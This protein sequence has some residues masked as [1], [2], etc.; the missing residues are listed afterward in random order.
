MAM[1]S[2]PIILYEWGDIATFHSVEQLVQWV[3]PEDIQNG[4]YLLFDS[5][6]RILEAYLI[7]GTRIAVRHLTSDSRFMQQIVQ[8]LIRSI[9]SPMTTPSS[10][11]CPQ[12]LVQ[13]AGLVVGRKWLWR[14]RR[15]TASR[16]VE[17]LE[18]N[19]TSI[20][21]YSLGR[22]EVFESI[23]QL[24]MRVT[25]KDMGLGGSLLFDSEGRVLDMTMIDE[26]QIAVHF[27]TAETRFHT[28]LT[29]MLVDYLQRANVGLPAVSSLHELVQAVILY[30]N[31]NGRTI[32]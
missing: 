3:E 11:I 4:E 24:Q 31:S 1:I 22:T 2:V 12:K 9:E 17:W 6:G 25:P 21:A 5:E 27:A 18:K 16:L 10:G 13:A 26:T 20:I 19:E 30:H 23:H 7:G 29:H 15:R 8:M 32:L 28:Q 14:N